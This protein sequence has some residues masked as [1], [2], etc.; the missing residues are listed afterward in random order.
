MKKRYFI[1]KWYEPYGIVDDMIFKVLVIAAS[2][3]E[4][5]NKVRTVKGVT[6]KLEIEECTPVDGIIFLGA[7]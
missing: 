6:G 4:A 5:K 3:E 1:V 2:E 7:E